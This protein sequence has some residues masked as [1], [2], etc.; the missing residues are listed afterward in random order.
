[1]DESFWKYWKR[2]FAEETEQKETKIR[3]T[4]PEICPLCKNELQE[5]W[6]ACPYCGT[7]IGGDTRIY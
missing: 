7:K 5:D 3:A 4:E 6:V 2:V 1:M